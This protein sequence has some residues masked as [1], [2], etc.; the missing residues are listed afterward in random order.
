MLTSANILNMTLH[1]M[2]YV[3]CCICQCWKLCTLCTRL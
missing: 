3:I 2:A 1:T